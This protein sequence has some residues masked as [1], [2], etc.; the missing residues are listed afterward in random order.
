MAGVESGQA[1]WSR[2]LLLGVATLIL[3]ILGITAGALAQQLP[4]PSSAPV[5]I[6]DVAE[7]PAPPDVPAPQ[8]PPE[9]EP[10]I[11]EVQPPL[12][13][14]PI[15]IDPFPHWNREET[16]NVLL[17][18]VDRREVNEIYRTDTLIL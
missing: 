17:V 3:P 11:E 8:L 14:A 18:G 5:E 7:D 2:S 4:Q 15:R 13:T 16:L 1:R 6:V 9:P 12:V 10:L